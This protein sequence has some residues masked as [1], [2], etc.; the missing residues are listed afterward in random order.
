VSQE[1]TDFI[2]AGPTGPVLGTPRRYYLAK[3]H[4]WYDLCDDLWL[5]WKYKQEQEPG[6]PLPADFPHLEELADD[7]YET[8]EDLAGSTVS[9][10]EDRGFSLSDS[11]EIVA[12]FAAL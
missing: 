10:F 8:I 6:T 7:G 4:Y 3:R 1:L 12:A 11:E 5:S 2:N 9:E